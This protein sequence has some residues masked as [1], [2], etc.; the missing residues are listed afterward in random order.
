[1][2]SL[3]PEFPASV[4]PADVG[5]VVTFHGTLGGPVE[6]PGFDLLAMLAAIATVESPVEAELIRHFLRDG[7]VAAFPTCHGE[8]DL[9]ERGGL[10]RQLNGHQPRPG[11]E[12]DRPG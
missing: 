8:A 7:K 11:P 12:A 4:R 1:M 3:L 10:F 6:H 2:H 5:V 9:I